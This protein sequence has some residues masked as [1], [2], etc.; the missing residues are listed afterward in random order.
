MGTKLAPV[1]VPKRARSPICNQQD[2]SAFGPNH[3][4]GL[5]VSPSATLNSASHDGGDGHADAIRDAVA[6]IRIPERHS[7]RVVKQSDS[8]LH[9]RQR[10]FAECQPD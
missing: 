8:H 1:I 10:R 7:E 6:E 5:S 3:E 9:S 2:S 4:F